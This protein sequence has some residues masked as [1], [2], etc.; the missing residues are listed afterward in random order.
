MKRGFVIQEN[1]V[2]YKHLQNIGLKDVAYAIAKLSDISGVAIVCSGNEFKVYMCDTLSF[3]TTDLK[4]VIKA[5]VDCANI[6]LGEG[7]Y[8][9]EDVPTINRY[10]KQIKTHNKLSSIFLPTQYKYMGNIRDSRVVRPVLADEIGIDRADAV[11]Y[12]LQECGYFIVPSD[13]LKKGKYI[14]IDKGVMGYTEKD[15]YKDGKVI[16]ADT[17]KILKHYVKE[18]YMTKSHAKDIVDQITALD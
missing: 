2:F 8:Y 12:G 6:Y 17:I 5:I 1:A 18:G 9:R 7:T 4:E 13:N 14:L 3:I 11:I 15:Y 16:K 10:L